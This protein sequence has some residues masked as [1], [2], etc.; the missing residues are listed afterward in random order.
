MTDLRPAGL[1]LRIARQRAG[2]TQ[3]E[4]AA[5]ASV[6]QATI[7][8]YERSMVEPRQEVLDC[9]AEKLDAP[10]LRKAS[11]SIEPRGS[12]AEDAERFVA[13]QRE[14][15]MRTLS[16]VSFPLAHYESPARAVSGDLAF[17]V[18]LGS[19]TLVVV[20]DGADKGLY[21][22]T[23][24]LMVASAIL[25]AVDSLSGG[26]SWPNELVQV[27]REFPARIG[28]EAPLAELFVGMVDHRN[29]M[30]YFARSNFPEP[31]FRVKGRTRLLRGKIGRVSD[32]WFGREELTDDSLVLVSTDGFTHQPSKMGAALWEGQE[33]RSHLHGAS[34]PH[35]VMDWIRRRAENPNLPAIGHD[36]MLVVAMGP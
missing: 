35:E 21:A 31:L 26:V 8:Y 34:S 7:S 19:H 4:A 28:L 15:F 18:H 20:V 5:L 10:E 3:K 14:A 29:R 25:G 6:S 16:S 30:L 36:D 33:L 13:E 24:A 9:L 12:S 32:V 27:A 22:A 23:R 11:T 1:L 2:L 17:A